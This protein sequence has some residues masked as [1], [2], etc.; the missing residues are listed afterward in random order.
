MRNLAIQLLGLI[1]IVVQ[2]QETSDVSKPVRVLFIGNSYTRQ[3]NLPE[4]VAQI[5][6]SKNRRLFYESVTPGGETL[7]NIGKRETLWKRST[8]RNGILSSFRIR[9]LSSK[10]S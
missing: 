7:R 10:E 8:K 6:N 4:M 3:H 1:P 2:G 9:V 5:A